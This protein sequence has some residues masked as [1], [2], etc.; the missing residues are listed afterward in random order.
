[1][2]G[3]AVATVTELSFN[4]LG[5]ISALVAT[6]NFSLQNI[7]SKKVRVFIDKVMETENFSY[8]GVSTQYT[9][10]C[11][12]ALFCKILYISCTQAFSSVRIC[13]WYYVVYLVV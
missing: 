6:V 3:I 7:F 4:V 5:L 1:M 10:F 8:K 12:Y 13:I 9:F 11:F 2:L